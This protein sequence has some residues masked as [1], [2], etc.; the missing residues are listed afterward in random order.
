[1]NDNFERGSLMIEALV[2]ITLVMVGLLGIFSLITRSLGMN[3]D[4]HDRFVAANLAS[5]GIEV[6]K[7]IIDTDVAAGKFWNSTIQPGNTYAVEYD[8]TAGSIGG[9]GAYVATPLN[10]DPSTG[11][12]SYTYAT[13]QSPFTRAVR[14]KNPA[15][16]GGIEIDSVVTWT[17]N[18]KDTTVE[19]SDT[20]TPWRQ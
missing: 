5:E 20:F 6:V 15:T 12:Y 13:Q 4:V 17:V 18:G 10:V 2:A 19:L 9:M 16:G 3:K 7:N 8:T 1:M 14:A 11:L